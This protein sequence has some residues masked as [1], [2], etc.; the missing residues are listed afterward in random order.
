MTG[1]QVK[2]L[3]WTRE[4]RRYQESP[5]TRLK[6]SMRRARQKAQTIQRDFVRRQKG[7]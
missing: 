5:A 1:E 7:N 3:A 6:K 4:K 2:A